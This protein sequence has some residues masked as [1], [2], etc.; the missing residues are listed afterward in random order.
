MNFCSVDLMSAGV[1]LR[2]ARAT[3]ECTANVVLAFTSIVDSLQNDGSN[4]RHDACVFSNLPHISFYVSLNFVLLHSTGQSVM[5]KC[6]HEI[7][8][9]S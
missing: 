7:V 8:Q 2:V 4:A 9:L 3:G 6:W 5:H 1:Q